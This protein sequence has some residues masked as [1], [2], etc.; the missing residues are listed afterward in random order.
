MNRKIQDTI[1]GMLLLV[2][3]LI[4]PACE[5]NLSFE[6]RLIEDDALMAAYI[7][8]NNLDAQKDE[9]GVYYVIEEEGS[10]EKPT[11]ESTVQMY[12]QGY[13]LDGF[14]FDGN[15]GAANPI[16]FPLEGLI[17]GWQIGIPYFGKGGKGTLLIPSAL[18]YGENGVP[19]A[20]IPENAVLAFDIELVDFE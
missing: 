19:Q 18:G 11:L 14:I 8:G 12:Y 10:T 16:E 3:L 20:G 2:A 9:S 17:S 1:L 7:E 6:E 4:S 13:L 5:N 15:L